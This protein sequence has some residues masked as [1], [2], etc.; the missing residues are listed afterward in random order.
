MDCRVRSQQHFNQDRREGA[1]LST[2]GWAGSGFG[3]IERDSFNKFAS[4]E[5]KQRAPLRRWFGCLVESGM[6]Q[7]CGHVI[8]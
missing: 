2:H 3:P 6:R 1:S 5:E 4:P 8:R 7:Y